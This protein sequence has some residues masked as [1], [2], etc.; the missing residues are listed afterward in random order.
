[1]TQIHVVSYNSIPS[2]GSEVLAVFSSEEKAEAWIASLP[3]HKSAGLFV[4]EFE[5]DK[6]PVL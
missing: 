1:M 3:N 6:E 2:E 4:E 5:L